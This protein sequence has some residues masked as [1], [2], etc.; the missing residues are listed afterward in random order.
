MLEYSYKVTAAR[1]APQGEL[2]NVIREVDVIVRGVDGAASFELPTSVKLGEA[3]EDNF[4]PFEDLTEAQIASW[5]QENPNLDG[6]RSHIALIVG[7]ELAKLEMEQKPL[8]WAPTP[9]P[10][11]LTVPTPSGD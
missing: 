5:L 10:A 2:P 4:T 6:V 3:D 1:V 8:P 11:D 7:R 9:N